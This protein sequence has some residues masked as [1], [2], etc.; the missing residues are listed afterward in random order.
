MRADAFLRRRLDR[1]ENTMKHVIKLNF[2]ANV[3][4]IE[5]DVP[6]PSLTDLLLHYTTTIGTPKSNA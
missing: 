2:M 1:N 6:T 3:V 4:S 5:Y